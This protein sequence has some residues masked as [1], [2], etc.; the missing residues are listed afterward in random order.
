MSSC[1][2]RIKKSSSAVKQDITSDKV[3]CK[4]ASVLATFSVCIL[5]P[6]APKIMH[7]ALGWLVKDK[8][9]VRFPSATS[10]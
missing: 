4:G 1:S 6:L 2:M 3:V 7:D 9:Y 8:Y 5:C 10:I